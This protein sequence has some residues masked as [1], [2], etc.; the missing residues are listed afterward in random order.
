MVSDR[1]MRMQY[2][3]VVQYIAICHRHH[4]PKLFTSTWKLK[5]LI[6]LTCFKYLLKDDQKVPFSYDYR[7]SLEKTN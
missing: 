5:K 6:H 2:I 4:P 3:I 7:G 1:G